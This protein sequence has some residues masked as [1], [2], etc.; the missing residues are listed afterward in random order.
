MGP[1]R[2]SAGTARVMRSAGAPS[3]KLILLLVFVE[4][5]NQISRRGGRVAEGAPLLRE[6]TVYPVSR[7]RIPLSPPYENKRAPCEPFCFYRDV[8]ARTLDVK[9]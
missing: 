2:A 5:D 8:G 9:I 7:V 1:D 3:S 4:A 6:Y